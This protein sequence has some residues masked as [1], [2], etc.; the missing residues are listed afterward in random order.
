M[1]DEGNGRFAFRRDTKAP[2]APDYLGIYKQEGDKV[3]ICYRQSEYG[4][5]TTFKFMDSCMLL[6][7]HRVKTRK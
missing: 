1:T 6:T 5:P 4:R 2:E 3:T 7:L